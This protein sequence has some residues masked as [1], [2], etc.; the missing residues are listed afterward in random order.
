M[1]VQIDTVEAWR[2][3]G[4][5]FT[6]W[7]EV[8]RYATRIG[9]IQP[10]GRDVRVVPELESSL[11]ETWYELGLANPWIASADDPPFTMDSFVGC[12]SLTELEDRIGHGNWAV[13]TAFYFQDV[14]FINQVD[15]GDEWLTIR[16]GVAF[17]SMTL[18][19]TIEDGR[20]A[21]LVTRLL[22]ASREQCERLEY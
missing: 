1:Q 7:V 14:C 4:M 6:S 16:H 11:R 5:A 13:G 17:E 21:S 9:L 8:Y 20:F 2:T 12:Y 15:G 18:I 22:T 10:N 3:I 19:P